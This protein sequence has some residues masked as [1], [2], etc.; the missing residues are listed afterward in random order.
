[1]K[2]LAALLALFLC[3]GTAVASTDA[4]TLLARGES[5][6]AHN[7]KNVIVIFHASWCGW[8]H[9]LAQFLTNDDFQK[10]FA[11]NYAIVH[12][13]VLEN[14]DKKNFETPGGAELSKK[15]GA[16][17]QGLPFYVILDYK[18]NRLIDSRNPASPDAKGNP[19]NIGF[20]AKPEEI[21]YFMTILK[22]TGRKFK[23]DDLTK[24]EAA[25]KNQKD[26]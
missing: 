7:G 10:T 12:I 25:L 15:L 4:N 18:G 17:H 26:D 1:V 8:C 3:L 13:D 11:R 21:A 5:E 24:I 16:D 2:L 6:A 23:P 14:A 20:P 9:K 22:T 19:Q